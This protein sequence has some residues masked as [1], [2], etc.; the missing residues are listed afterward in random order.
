MDQSYGHFVI[1]NTPALHVAESLLVVSVKS[2]AVSTIS[3][4][5]YEGLELTHPCRQSKARLAD[6]VVLDC[7][8]I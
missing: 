7:E 6:E 5:K 2:S 3:V 1:D 8:G 4:M